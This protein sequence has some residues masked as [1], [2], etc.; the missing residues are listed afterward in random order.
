MFPRHE[1]KDEMTSQLK[2]STEAVN[3]AR[4]IV[5]GAS[6]SI[7]SRLLRT[8]APTESERLLRARVNAKELIPRAVQ[9]IQTNSHLLP[10]GQTPRSMKEIFERVSPLHAP[11]LITA[12]FAQQT[13]DT[14]R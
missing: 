5:A 9:V 6:A 10:P 7:P 3:E 12:G 11:S 4:A 8:L 2:S 14:Q 1:T 13:E